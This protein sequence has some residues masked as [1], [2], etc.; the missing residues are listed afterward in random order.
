V[1]PTAHTIFSALPPSAVSLTGN[2]I[3]TP[4][5]VIAATIPSEILAE[6]NDL[7]FSGIMG[8]LLLEHDPVKPKIF[9]TEAVESPDENNGDQ[10]ESD[11]A[12]DFRNSLP[13]L[14]AGRFE[15]AETPVKGNDSTSV[16]DAMNVFPGIPP[17]GWL[18][19][20]QPPHGRAD[21]EFV[22]DRPEGN[23]ISGQTRNSQRDGNIQTHTTALHRNTPAHPLE[24]HRQIVASTSHPSMP[25]PAQENRMTPSPLDFVEAT[26][27]NDKTQDHYFSNDEKQG[28]LPEG[29]TASRSAL[30]KAET[31]D[32]ALLHELKSNTSIDDQQDRLPKGETTSRSVSKEAETINL[33]PLNEQ[34]G[35]T[36]FWRDV[37]NLPS[38]HATKSQN[39]P[40]KIEIFNGAFSGGRARNA[41]A[42]NMESSHNTSMPNQRSLAIEEV[43][44]EPGAK[45]EDFA[46]ETL[47]GNPPAVPGDLG[48]VVHAGRGNGEV[49]SGQ[50]IFGKLMETQLDRLIEAIRDGWLQMR[51]GRSDLRLQLEPQDLGA[52]RIALSLQD[53]G[54]ICRLETETDETRSLLEAGVAELKKGL[55]AHGLQI[56]RLEVVLSSHNSLSQSETSN[57]EDTSAQ[58]LFNK[59]HADRR[60]PREGGSNKLASHK[61]AFLLAGEQHA[62]AP[63]TSRN[64]DQHR[65]ELLV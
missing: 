57:P 53:A 38:H 45:R 17:S 39:S 31:S 23:L 52:I 27:E 30:Q 11:Q 42:L 24:E 22:G 16:L 55:S 4:G 14:P 54:L 63:L 48:N 36:S 56:E 59:E 9:A 5:G 47:M 61:G 51:N 19:V 44:F 28:R 2:S 50:I 13:T 25:E 35:N 8:R 64:L 58:L 15:Y 37:R 10:I 43:A 40:Q 18:L 32:L 26:S 49:F 6:A 7:T 46:P 12:P 21:R 65:I 41:P 29:E 34:K 62:T 3:A 60:P 1:N 20:E 33:A